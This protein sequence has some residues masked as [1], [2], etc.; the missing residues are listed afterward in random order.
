MASKEKASISVTLN[1]A[2]GGTFVMTSRQ[3]MEVHRFLALS[4]MFFIITAASGPMLVAQA[5]PLLCPANSYCVN[6]LMDGH[7]SHPGDNICSTS[8]VSQCTLRAAI[9]EAVAIGGAKTIKLLKGIHKLTLGELLIAPQSGV[10]PPDLLIEGN[11]TPFVKTSVLQRSGSSLNRLIS[12]DNGASV[13]LQRVTV[14]DG[15]PPASNTS[16][17]HGGGISNKG[18]LLIE[19]SVITNNRTGTSS[20]GGGIYN[21]GTMTLR[22]SRVHLNEA[23]GASIGGGIYSS[24]TLI[25]ENSVIRENVSD[26]HG[27]AIYTHG[28]ITILDSTIEKNVS[29]DYGGGLSAD[30]GA[31][32]SIERSTISANQSR[33]GGGISGS[34]LFSIINTTISGNTALFGDGGAAQVTTSEFHL[35]NST[36]KDNAGTKSSLD[37]NVKLQNTIVDEKPLTKCP[38]TH[39]TSMGYNILWYTSGSTGSCSLQPTDK[40]TDP[41]LSGLAINAPGKTATHALT[42]ASPA[43]D[44]IPHANSN[45]SPKT[46][47]R[48]VTRPQ[49]P[50]SQV[51]QANYD[52]GAYE[53][54]TGKCLP[55]INC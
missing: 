48:G 42:K 53:Y 37:G 13:T 25:I 21:E 43:R 3:S 40:T 34:G 2:K 12:V 26:K 23:K 17:Y 32:V 31:K 47:Q 14:R 50:P 51:F 36:V 33:R 9:E 7:D 22:G 35:L 16:G 29:K 20:K 10:A 19:N 28:P 5:Q 54:R 6:T 45:G 30:S 8:T 41:K 38:V 11:A 44:A 24:G 46:D 1:R 4:I 52:I 55:G 15:R 27:G 18:T 39:L 49:G